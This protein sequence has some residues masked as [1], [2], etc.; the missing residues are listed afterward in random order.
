MSHNLE[1]IATYKGPIQ[2]FENPTGIVIVGNFSPE[3]SDA[4]DAIEKA[5]LERFAYFQG[6]GK[7][8][9]D[10]TDRL[11]MNKTYRLFGR[12]KGYFNKRRCEE[13]TQF[14]FTDFVEHT[15]QSKPGLIDYLSAH[16]KGKRIGPAKARMLVEHIGA[17][18][19]LNVCRTDHERIAEL[20]GIEIHQA[21]AF[22]DSL[23]EQQATEN[24]VLELNAILGKRGFPKTLTKKLV[25]RWRNSAPAVIQDDPYLLMD[26]RGVGFALADKLWLDLGKDVR[27][28]RRQTMC[29]WSI[30][31]SNREGHIW[32][33]ADKVVQ[34][35]QAMIPGD[36]DAREAILHGKEIA[37]RNETPHGALATIR[38][39]GKEGPLAT[40]GDTLWIAI[41]S[42]AK[43]EREIAV[44]LAVAKDETC[45]DV[46]TR[47]SQEEDIRFSYL[48]HAT[49]ARCHRHLTAP[50]VHVLDERPYG[51]TCITKMPGG[52]TAEALPLEVW[53]KQNPIVDRFIR[54]EPAGII[55]V[56]EALLWPDPSM[57]HGENFSD[58]QRSALA[59]AT[60]E[61]VGILTGSPGTGK[62][63]SIAA[64]VRAVLHA[65]F[66][67]M[68]QIAMAAPTGKAAVRMTQSLEEK[69]LRMQCRT[70][71]SLLGTSKETTSETDGWAF[72]HGKNMPWPYKIII[73][74]EDSMPDVPIKRCIFDARGHGTHF[75]FVG[76]VNQ[77]AP[78]GPG[79]PL[80]DMIAAGVPTGELT[81]IHRNAGG[82]VKACK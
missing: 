22:A 15:P 49:C 68:H 77:L 25:K 46:M 19:V 24:T 1:I 4:V 60:T 43:D 30:L 66:V 70:W 50:M 58:H 21:R 47:Y 52:E 73:G 36:T 80:R 38:T 54:E 74:D 31:N 55:R 82:I 39:S 56:T 12:W 23:Q 37:A 40:D 71:H 28:I 65:G 14:C 17:D 64:L 32:H 62:T 44:A 69:G 42:L 41:D 51:P 81:E 79:A 33:R 53:I 7:D 13:I 29:L 11:V 59:D 34:K 35:F 16:G 78:V 6:K 18:E 45:V 8:G 67:G 63:T 10:E 3:G 27:D 2:Q 61:R 57:I 72:A 9:T 5:G 20:I 75:L 26:F 76:D 48:H